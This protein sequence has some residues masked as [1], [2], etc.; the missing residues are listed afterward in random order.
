M[1][2]VVSLPFSYHSIKVR[3]MVP[4]AGCRQDPGSAFCCTLPSS[5]AAGAQQPGFA[6]R[7][8]TQWSPGKR[9]AGDAR[10]IC[11]APKGLAKPSQATSY[12]GMALS[13]THP[14]LR[15]PTRDKPAP[16]G[17]VPRAE[18]TCFPAVAYHGENDQGREEAHDNVAHQLHQLVPATDREA[19]WR[20]V[21]RE[22]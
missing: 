22:H 6:G 13:I 2:A 1:V 3:S 18:P 19:A 11:W 21:Q 15:Q 4:A 5:K 12:L 14:G 9:S 10:G 20:Q 17:I 7:V 16:L 8:S